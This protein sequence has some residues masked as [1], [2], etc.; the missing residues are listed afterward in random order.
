MELEFTLTEADIVALVRYQIEH[1]LSVKRRI[2]RLHVGYVLGFA[3]LALGFY[4]LAPDL[5]LQLPFS[6]L[7][8]ASVALYRPLA[9]ARLRASAPRMARERMRP[10][11]VGWRK[12]RVSAEAM[13]QWSEHAES[14][15]EWSLVDGIDL[16]PTHAFVSV[17]GIVTLA[18]PRD[19]VT[20]GNFDDFMKGALAI[21][22]AA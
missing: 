15:V 7:A 3:L 14:K 13:Q 11:S 4:L 12:L 20:R 19:R 10:E 18:I 21:R 22:A 1:S 5:H 16:Q 9:W 17:G 6:L 8:V 2:A